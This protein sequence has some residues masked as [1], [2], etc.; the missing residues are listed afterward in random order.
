MCLTLDRFRFFYTRLSKL[1]IW[2]RPIMRYGLAGEGCHSL[3]F[4]VTIGFRYVLRNA[5]LSRRG[6]R[7]TFD[8]WVFEVFDFCVFSGPPR[9]DSAH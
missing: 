5:E 3:P 6:R 7:Q 2:G 9:K 8:I 4:L 1:D